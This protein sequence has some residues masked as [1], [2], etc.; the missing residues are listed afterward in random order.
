MALN[1]ILI[2]A[3]GMPGAA[4]A[5]AIS[6]GLQLVLHYG[7]CRFVLGKEEYPFTVG[8]WL[9][10]G[11]GYGAVMIF[12]YLTKELWLLRWVAGAVLGILELRQILRRKA[13]I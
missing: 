10:Y 9:K 1:Y 2:R 13:L 3:I 12:V 5:T 7:Y 11:I 4:L 8:V 6:H